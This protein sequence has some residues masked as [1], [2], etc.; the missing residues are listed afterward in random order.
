MTLEQLVLDTVRLL[1][2]Q[3]LPPEG[4]RALARRVGSRE[5]WLAHLLTSRRSLSAYP[6]IVAAIKAA[7]L[8]VPRAASER[9]QPGDDAA[10]ER[11]EFLALDAA[12]QALFAGEPRD[13]AQGEATDALQRFKFGD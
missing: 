9:P 1:E 13:G 12:L 5:E 10:R 4:A 7:A 11:Q 2:G 8:A 3:M 6:E